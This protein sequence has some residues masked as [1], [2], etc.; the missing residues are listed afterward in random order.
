MEALSAD[1]NNKP[2]NYPYPEKERIRASLAARRSRGL[3]RDVFAMFG[4]VVVFTE[5]EYDNV[6]KLK[7]AL[8]MRDGDGVAEGKGKVMLLGEDWVKD[9]EWDAKVKN[10]KTLLKKHLFRQEMGWLEPGKS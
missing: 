1:Y 7:D 8:K 2:F 6:V 4:F 10:M 5:K 3:K 9:A